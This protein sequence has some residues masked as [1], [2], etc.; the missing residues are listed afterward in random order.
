MK[1]AQMMLASK[2]ESACRII[3]FMKNYKNE[4]KHLHS[5]WSSL[6]IQSSHTTAFHIVIT[7]VATMAIT[8]Q[9]RQEPLNPVTASTSGQG[10]PR[11]HGLWFGRLLLFLEVPPVT[12]NG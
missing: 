6:R 5:R 2:V 9:K 4:V 8:A 1:K 7:N 12:S 3:F 10:F 11:C